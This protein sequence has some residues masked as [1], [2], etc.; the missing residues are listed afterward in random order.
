MEE[1]KN[2]SM[3]KEKTTK[4]LFKNIRKLV[5][6]MVVLGLGVASFS[7]FPS[8]SII[9]TIDS[10]A[11]LNL[12]GIISPL[13]SL[14]ITG[15]GAL[16]IGANAVKLGKN[17]KELRELDRYTSD[18]MSNMSK[19]VDDLK[20]ENDKLKTENLNLQKEKENITDKVKESLQEL[21]WEILNPSKD[22]LS[23]V[24]VKTVSKDGKKR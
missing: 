12:G 13:I 21:R 9:E 5:T 3:Q 8:L 14:V 2:I 20:L 7:I 10:L 11:A 18:Y 1:Y 17:K 19:M 16:R 24:L 6:G 22:E 23:A 4:K 15:L